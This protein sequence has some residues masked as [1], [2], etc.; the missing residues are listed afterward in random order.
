MAH[1]SSCRAV[2]FGL[3]GDLLYTAST[4]QSILALDVATGKPAARKKDAHGAAI[5]RLAAVSEAVVASGDD[6]GVVRLWDRRA[7]EAAASLEAHDDYVADLCL[8]APEDALLSVSGDGTLAVLDLRKRKIRAR[9]EG[10]ADDE[11][12]SVAPLK[13]G[14]KIVCVLNIWSW[15]YWNDCS[16]RFPGHPDSVAALVAYDSDTVLTGSGDG[17][18]RVLSVQPNKLLGV[19]GEHADYPVERMA[20]A[21]DWHLLASA[22]H[23]N[24]VKIWDLS[25]LD[26]DGEEEEEEEEKEVAAAQEQRHMEPGGTGEAGPADAAPRTADAGRRTQAAR[27]AAAR[28][29]GGSDSEEES[30]AEEEQ[31]RKKKRKK[32]AHRIPTKQQHK[33]SGGGGGGN[34]FAGLL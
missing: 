26:D 20:M 28:R 4:D 19:L 10:D 17:M 2:R 33:R 32:G 24:S 21:A 29:G 25:V 22:S 13:G 14:R 27:G 16:D 9:S 1:S 12:L 31:Q 5:N 34:F 30:D 18:I 11:L 7:A 6:E 8:H 15:G 23:D 3:G